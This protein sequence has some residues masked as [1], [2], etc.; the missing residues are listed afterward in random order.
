MGE[1]LKAQ[2]EQ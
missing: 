2:S 1:W